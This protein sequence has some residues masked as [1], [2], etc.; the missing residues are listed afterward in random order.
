MRCTISLAPAP[1]AVQ[2]N[3]FS[4]PSFAAFPGTLLG[5]LSCFLPHVCQTPSPAPA[6]LAAPQLSWRDGEGSKE[7]Q[8]KPWL[9]AHPSPQV[10][11]EPECLSLCPDTPPGPPLPLP[12]S[13]QLTVTHRSKD[14]PAGILN[15][16]EL[17]GPELWILQAN[18]CLYLHFS[19][20]RIFRDP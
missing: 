18:L 16:P 13:Q 8:A 12:T 5:H 14:A 10:G 20:N 19:G 4:S 6:A 15:H 3:L 7:T 2:K 11:A 1:A 17:Q 9:P